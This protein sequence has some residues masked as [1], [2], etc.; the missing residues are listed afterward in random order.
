MCRNRTGVGGSTD[1]TL[2]YFGQNKHV[3]STEQD[4]YGGVPDGCIH[5]PCGYLHQTSDVANDTSSV[6]AK[7]AT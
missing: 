2:S 3:M 5:P 7:N 4:G 6:H 1:A